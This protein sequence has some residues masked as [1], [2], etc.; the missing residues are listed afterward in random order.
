MARI[1]AQ[2]WRVVAPRSGVNSGANG[3][4]G[5]TTLQSRAGSLVRSSSA[6]DATHGINP[7]LSK[8]PYDAVNDFAPITLVA[9]AQGVLVVNP[10]V[11][12]KTVKELIAV[13]KAKPGSLNYASAGNGTAPH[14]AAEMFKLMT[15]TDLV[16]VPYKGSGPRPWP[17]PSAGRR[18]SCS[19]ASSPRPSTSRQ[20]SC[21]DWR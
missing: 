8:L 19:Q 16:H 5:S 17:T 20:D 11:P 15:G 1:I 6:G 18:R 7:A 2:K 3:A 9:E 4:I 13:A 12:A 10:G 14:I 21:A